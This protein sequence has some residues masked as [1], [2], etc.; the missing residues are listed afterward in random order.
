MLLFVFSLS[1]WS[2]WGRVLIKWRHWRLGCLFSVIFF[3]INCN[4]AKI[5]KERCNEKEKCMV[6][7]FNICNNKKSTKGFHLLKT[8]MV[9]PWRFAH[10]ADLITDSQAKHER[11]KSNYIELEKKKFFWKTDNFSRMESK[12]WIQNRGFY[13]MWWHWLMSLFFLFLFF[14]L[15]P[16]FVA[17]F[18][19]FY[20]LLSCLSTTAGGCH[21]WNKCRTSSCCFMIR[22]NE[23]I[24]IK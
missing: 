1:L 9:T 12:Q 24:L 6:H 14:L 21:L 19:N 16:L 11:G 18:P 22:R 10:K 17:R 8:Q 23:I 13:P 20:K 5:L 4:K 2:Q 7:R 15:Q 3:S